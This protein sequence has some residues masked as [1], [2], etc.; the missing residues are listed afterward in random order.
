MFLEAMQR[1]DLANARG[2]LAPNFEMTFPGKVHM[3]TLEELVAWGSTRYLKVSKTYER[4]DEVQK[5]GATVVYCFGTL[6]GIWLDGSAFDGVRFIDRFEIREGLFTRQDVWN[7]LAE[8]I[9]GSG[10]SNRTKPSR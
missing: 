5:D 3:N 9:S 6:F 1:R 2:F 4:F 8:V 7:D 10:S